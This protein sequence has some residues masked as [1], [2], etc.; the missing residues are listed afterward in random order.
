MH[1]IENENIRVCY[2]NKKKIPWSVM[3]LLLSP[4]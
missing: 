4:F 1:Y 2:Y 3:F